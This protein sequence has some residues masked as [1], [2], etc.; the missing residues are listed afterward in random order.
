MSFLLNLDCS[1]SLFYFVPQENSFTVQL[2]RLVEPELTVKALLNYIQWWLWQRQGGGVLWK[3]GPVQKI[4]CHFVADIHCTREDEATNIPNNHSHRDKKSSDQKYLWLGWQG[5]HDHPPTWLW[6]SPTP[7]KIRTNPVDP[8][9][10][11]Q[12]KQCDDTAHKLATVW[13]LWSLTDLM[14][15]WGE[16]FST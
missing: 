14:W 13:E 16:I 9:Q 5:H 7:N 2:A 10:C 6:F 11:E 12:W 8:K 3:T 15:P 4:I 1:Q